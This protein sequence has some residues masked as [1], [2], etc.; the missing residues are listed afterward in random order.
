MSPHRWRPQPAVERNQ[1]W[2][3]PKTRFWRRAAG[4]DC[5]SKWPSW[6]RVDRSTFDG[7]AKLVTNII[8]PSEK[9]VLKRDPA[10]QSPAVRVDSYQIHRPAR[11]IFWNPK[12][13]KRRVAN[14][15]ASLHSCLARTWG[16]LPHA[17][18][19]GERPKSWQNPC[20][21]RERSQETSFCATESEE[22]WC[23]RGG[24]HLLREVV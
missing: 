23:V 3:K 11:E 9:S 14:S 18:A 2:R 21:L 4:A 22:T 17:T 16:D 7:W 6:S 10:D 12:M 19:L 24:T 8:R 1:P 20:L 13:T 15:A 5:V